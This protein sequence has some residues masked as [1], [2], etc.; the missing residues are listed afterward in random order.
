MRHVKKSLMAV[1]ALALLLS[2]AGCMGKFLS[3]LTLGGPGECST[4]CPPTPA[5]LYA[6][7]P[8]HV[9]ALSINQ[10]TGALG[11]ALE[12]AG[13]NQSTGMTAPVSLG[14]L[15][16]SDFVNDTVQGFSINSNTGGLTAIAGSPFP[17]SGTAP[18]AGGLSAS[19]SG[20]AYLY[21]TDLN[22]GEVDGFAFD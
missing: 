20:G 3:G 17:L 16:V 1:V 21:A 22:A 15:Y 18:G 11:P 8:D 5:F 19:V 12:M 2:L 13:P 14:R 10:T 6:S 7:S 9:S 4:N